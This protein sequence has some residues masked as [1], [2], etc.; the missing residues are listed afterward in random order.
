MHEAV[1]TVFPIVGRPA[2]HPKIFFEPPVAPP[3][4][5]KSNTPLGQHPPI[6]NEVPPPIRKTNPPMKSE[7]HFYELIPRISTINNN[8]KSS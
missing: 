5:I 6:K 8:L 7:A 3:P 1:L 4:P 2:P